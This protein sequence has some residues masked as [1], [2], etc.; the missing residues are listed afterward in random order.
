MVNIYTKDTEKSYGN[1]N[2][3]DSNYAGATYYKNKNGQI[4]YIETWSET[5]LGVN[6]NDKLIYFMDTSNV[7][8]TNI[9]KF[10]GIYI[11]NYFYND[12][13]LNQT[14]KKLVVYYTGVSNKCRIKVTYLDY[15]T[16]VIIECVK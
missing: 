2:S 9:P 7:Q 6:P 10:N 1:K 4:V 14:Q 5:S 16:K 8:I 3:G 11:S 13:Y 12:N 15:F